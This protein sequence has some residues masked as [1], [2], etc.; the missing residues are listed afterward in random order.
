MKIGS[1]PLQFKRTLA[2]E[3]HRDQKAHGFTTESDNFFDAPLSVGSRNGEPSL[4][5]LSMPHRVP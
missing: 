2:T 3:G 1:A 5:L 4:F